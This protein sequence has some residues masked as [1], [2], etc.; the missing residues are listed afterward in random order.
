[1]NVGFL[2]VIT[3]TVGFDFGTEK[4]Q[5]TMFMIPLVVG[6]GL[7]AAQELFHWIDGL[8]LNFTKAISLEFWRVDLI[9]DRNR[10]SGGSFAHKVPKCTQLLLVGMINWSR[11]TNYTGSFTKMTAV[12]KRGV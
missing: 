6:T 5:P 11:C 1:M 4:R 8:I 2:H 10:A 9:E 12:I 3:N 7:K